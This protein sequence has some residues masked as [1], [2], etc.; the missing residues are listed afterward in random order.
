MNENIIENDQ[1]KKNIHLFT[2]KVID[3]NG[4]YVIYEI[5]GKKY[6]GNSCFSEI[7]GLDNGDIVKI[8]ED[9]FNELWV[10]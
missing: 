6:I 2:A 5:D 9:R 3:I 8:R 10:I 4:L 1:N 7:L